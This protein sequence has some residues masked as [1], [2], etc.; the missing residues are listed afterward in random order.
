MIRWVGALLA[1]TA[2]DVVWAF[3]V[4]A[5]ADGQALASGIL[6]VLIYLIGTSVLLELV[7][8]RKLLLPA[9]IGAFIGTYLAVEFFK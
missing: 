4:R 8:D 9:C 5:L 1:L 2:V 3:Y 6:S 7:K